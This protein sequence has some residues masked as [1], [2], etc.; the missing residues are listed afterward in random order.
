MAANIFSDDRDGVLQRT[1][2]IWFEWRT[3]TR[4]TRRPAPSPAPAWLL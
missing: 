3:V 2:L 1:K 4:S